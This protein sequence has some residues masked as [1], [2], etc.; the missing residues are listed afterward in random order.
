M[1]ED[2]TVLARRPRYGTVCGQAHPRT[3]ARARASRSQGGVLTKLLMSETRL[4]VFTAFC[5]QALV[6]RQRRLDH[7]LCDAAG[8]G[9]H[10]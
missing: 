6:P 5:I 10:V 3:H 1:A 2:G 8:V 7:P 4:P 9:G